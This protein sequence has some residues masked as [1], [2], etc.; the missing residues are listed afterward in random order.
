MDLKELAETL[1]A[2]LGRDLANYDWGGLVVRWGDCIREHGGEPDEAALWN[3][4]SCVMAAASSPGSFQPKLLACL[5]M[6]GSQV[7]TTY[8]CLLEALS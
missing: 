8:Q 6:L 2:K 1:A 4:T 7:I 3:F 5:S